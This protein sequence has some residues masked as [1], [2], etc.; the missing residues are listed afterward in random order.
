MTIPRHKGIPFIPKP[1][2]KE[3]PVVEELVDETP[4]PLQKVERPAMY[5]QDIPILVPEY[6]TLYGPLRTK[7]GWRFSAAG[8][9]NGTV[10]T[11]AGSTVLSSV[12]LSLPANTQSPN[13]RLEQWPGGVQLYL[14]IRMFSMGPQTA[15][16][17]TQGEIDVLYIS[18][19]GNTVPLG[20]IPNNG[21]TKYS[22]YTIIPGAWTDSGDQA[23]LGNLS[24][25]LNSG[26]TTG[27]YSWQ[28]GL[29][30][31]YLLPAINAYKRERIN[32]AIYA[33]HMHHRMHS[34]EWHDN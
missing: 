21:F 10:T 11:I 23:N 6:N 31:A 33:E 8:Y 17:I 22:D 2:R 16:F 4:H 30:A 7:D 32:D 34:H 19:D 25:T 18:R 9:A 3:K 20:I 13:W 28:I 5:K 1:M 27:T 15:S 29:G 26:A 12:S 24:F 14:V